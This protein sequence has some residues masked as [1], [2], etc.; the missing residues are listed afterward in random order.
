[1]CMHDVP[2]IAY[3]VNILLC[4]LFTFNNWFLCMKSISMAFIVS[5]SYLS[6]I[7]A[8]HQIIS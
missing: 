5:L 3:L 4:I 6:H 7:L 2:L 8:S 1:M